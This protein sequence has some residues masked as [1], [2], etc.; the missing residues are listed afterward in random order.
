[1][2][3]VVNDIFAEAV[4]LEI[5]LQ[6][7]DRRIEVAVRAAKLP[8]EREIRRVEEALTAAEGVDAVRTA[9]VNRRGHLLRFGI[10]HAEGVVESIGNVEPL[11]VGREGNAARVVSDGNSCGHVLGCGGQCV[12]GG[13]TPRA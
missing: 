6:T 4:R 11:A 5:P 13:V 12:R 9:Q 7:V 2:R 1:E 3:T 8:L 10:D